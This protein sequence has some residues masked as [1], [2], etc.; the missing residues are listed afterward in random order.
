MPLGSLLGFAFS[1]EH[2]ESVARNDDLV[3]KV[4]VTLNELYNGAMKTISYTKRVVD[5]D[6]KTCK[7]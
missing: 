5:G 2:Y 3:V 1:A 6:G 4:E 7:D